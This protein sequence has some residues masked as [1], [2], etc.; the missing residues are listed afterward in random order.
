MKSHVEEI[1]FQGPSMPEKML[2]NLP[3]P[4]LHLKIFSLGIERSMSFKLG[5]S[6]SATINENAPQFKTSKNGGTKL[7]DMITGTHS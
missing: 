4:Q 2:L 5:M 1:I 7:S 6:F 3:D